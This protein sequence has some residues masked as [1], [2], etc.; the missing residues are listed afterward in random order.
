MLPGAG[1]GDGVTDSGGREMADRDEEE[2]LSL[3]QVFSSVLASFGGV[4]SEE[5]RRRDF[6]RGRPR[7]FI[8]VGLLLTVLF[9]LAV[10]GL[11]RLVMALALPD[12]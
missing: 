1:D 2:R 8:I 11:V 9:I 4:Q 5:R 3:W 6:T 12:R 7:D 10:W